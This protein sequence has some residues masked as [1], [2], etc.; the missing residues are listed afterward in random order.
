MSHLWNIKFME[1]QI[2]LCLLSINPKCVGGKKS[3]RPPPLSPNCTCTS[4]WCRPQRGLI[5]SFDD[6]ASIVLNSHILYILYNLRRKEIFRILSSF[7]SSFH[8]PNLF[9]LHCIEYSISFISSIII[10]MI[11]FKEKCRI[12]TQV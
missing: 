11:K 4:R 5:V 6:A 3:S 8:S 9:T 10:K 2:Y 12:F 1:W 7:H